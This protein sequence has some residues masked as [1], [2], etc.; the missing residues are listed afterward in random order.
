MP[1]PSQTQDQIL[2]RYAD[3]PNLLVD[4]ID[5]LV[6]TQLDL[7]L[8][9]DSWSIRQL[10]HHIADGDYLWKEFLLR[11]A[12][13]SDSE[14]SLEWYWCLP[15]DEWVK[16]W[17]YAERDISNSLSLLTANRQHTLDLLRQVPWLWEKGL[18]IPTRQGGQ[19]RVTVGEVV[20]MQA[21]HVEGHVEDIRKIRQVHGV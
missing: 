21:R 8:S 14:F 4:S 19:E 1:H 20:E 6:D 17:S 13:D 10:I 7:T 5:G 18:L 3:G 12:G 15:Q 11:A 9:T 2:A 16:R